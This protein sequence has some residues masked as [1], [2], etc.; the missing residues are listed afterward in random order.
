MGAKWTQQRVGEALPALLEEA[1]MSSRA[2]ARAIGIDQA[3][4]SRVMNGHLPA[5]AEFAAR[6]SEEFGLPI[7]YFADYREASVVE[8]VREDPALRDRV[9]RR[10]ASKRRV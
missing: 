8:A 5:S 3:H 6:V 4:I 1:G 10:L 2:L 9:Y 7:D